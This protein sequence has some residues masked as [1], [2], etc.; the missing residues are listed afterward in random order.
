MGT[1]ATWPPCQPREK[2]NRG[3]EREGRDAIISRPE[4][5]S[6]IS[7]ALHSDAR[8]ELNRTRLPPKS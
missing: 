7:I 1:E 3:G 5:S 2:I 4:V 6:T 8:Y